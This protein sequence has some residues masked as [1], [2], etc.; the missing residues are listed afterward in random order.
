MTVKI[1]LLGAANPETKR[2][3]MAV[4]KA[5]PNFEV[6]G[7]VDNDPAKQG[8]R[9]LGYPILGG[10]EVL[11]QLNAAGVYFVNLITGS[12]R[13]RYETSRYMASRGCRFATFIHPTVDLTMVSMGLGNYVQEGVIIQANARIGDSSSI[14]MGALVAH[15]V[16]V[17]SSVFIAHACSISGSVEIGD[18]V[19]VGTNATIIPRLR[20]GKWATIGAGAVVIKDVPDYATVVGNPAK[21]VKVAEPLYASGA[22]FDGDRS[23]Q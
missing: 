22:I 6:A 21:V 7:F 23:T 13:T 2:M 15:E 1:V 5:Q 4:E 18:G 14:H 16:T 8:Q 17:G 19:F 11:D 12:T 20:I 9:F 3:I 10:F